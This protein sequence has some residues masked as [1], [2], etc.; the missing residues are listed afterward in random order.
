MDFNEAYIFD[1][2][3]DGLLPEVS[4]IHC[5]SYINL[6]TKT[7]TT[8]SIYEHILN[9]FSKKDNILIG[10]NIVQYDIAVIEKLF[11][12]KVKSTLIDTLGLSWT[13]SPERDKHGLES[14]GDFF[15]IEKPKINDWSNLTKEEYFNRCEKDVEINTKLW[16]YQDNYLNKLYDTPESKNKYLQYITFK[17]DCLK[18]QETTG[19]T[20]DK[21][22]CISSLNELEAI[23]LE[24]INKLTVAM[25][26]VPIKNYK[27]LPKN[28]Y[29]AN[30]ELSLLGIKWLEFLKEKGLPET[31]KEEIE[32]IS[33]YEEPNPNSHDQL[34]K[35][36]FSLGWIPEHI[37]HQRDKKK[38]EIKKIPQIKSKD[39]E[40]E[41][42]QSIKKLI[43]KEPALEE[44]NGLFIVSHRITIYKGF[45]R[46]ERNGKL[47]QG[48]SG[49]TNTLRLQHTGIVNLPSTSKLYAKNIRKCLKTVDNEHILIG[50][51]LSGIEDNTKRHYIYQYDPEY[52]EQMNKPDFD[53]HLD[54]AVLAGFLTT[55]QAEKHKNGEENHKNVRQ[56]AKT[57]N[58]ALTYKCGV[59]TL[60][61]QTGLKEKEAKKLS[62]VYWKRNKAIL[63][64]EK[65][66]KVKDIN[67]QKWILNPIS[68]FWYSLRT[69]K[70]KFST[71]NQGSAVFVF[72]TWLQKLRAKNTKIS[73]QVHDEWTS[74][75]YSIYKEYTKNKVLQCI[76]EVNEELKLN[77]K[78]GC[79]ID[80]GENYSECH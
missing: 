61:R 46:D 1:I 73:F 52:V 19:I 57:A 58:F 31:H 17:L 45:L 51:D 80:F 15:G 62:E 28:M 12:I 70:D 38:N 27:S 37:K 5:L 48:A 2:E 35:W 59:A 44:L 50:C 4:K 16:E 41:I 55:E 56:K 79:S 43:E 69:E 22:L 40:G 13:L 25:P 9:F 76:E 14:W 68:N 53:P 29:K 72:D 6:K 64:V 18:E 39:E 33:G 75:I 36:L 23:K 7:K 54:I 47:H 78:I 49:L 67:E 26:K 71:L 8:T 21:E 42:C 65:S 60:M 20:L 74:E 66:L 11:N 3:T 63:E 10:H 77:V 30:G 32:Y 34:K 24:K